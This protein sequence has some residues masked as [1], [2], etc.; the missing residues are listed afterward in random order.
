MTSRPHYYLDTSALIESYCGDSRTKKVLAG[1][2]GERSHASSTQVEREWMSNI[3]GAC[4]DILNASQGAVDRADVAARLRSGFARAPSRRWMVFEMAASGG[5]LDEVRAGARDL[6]RVK[7]RAM[8]RARVDVLR[9]GSGCPIGKRAART[10]RQGRLSYLSTCRKTEQI[11]TQ[12]DFL[13]Q[14]KARALRAA[15]QLADSAPRAADRRMGREARRA[16]T[17]GDPASVKGKACWGSRGLGGDISIALECAEN[18]VLLTSDQSYDT[19][20]PALGMSH[21][22]FQSTRIS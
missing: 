7:A 11:C 15:G 5:D 9:D 17:S 10:D 14:E 1:M 8:L 19:I 6:M 18:E 13:A 21:H 16:L 20:C 3:L 22:R 12:A 4:A 2:L